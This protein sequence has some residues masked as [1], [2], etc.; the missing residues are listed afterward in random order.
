MRIYQQSYAHRQKHG[1]STAGDKPSLIARLQ[2]WILL[3]NSNLDTSHPKSLPALRAALERAEGSRK[4]DREKGK[5]AA[6]EELGTGKGLQQ[7]AKEK[8][9]EFERL[10]QEI[11]E[12]DRRR[13]AQGQE[14]GVGKDSA[15]EVE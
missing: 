13:N 14:L 9:S 5:D 10:R 12:R 3:Y 4:R 11:I 2:E 7:Y 6:V 15:I 8:R 1:L